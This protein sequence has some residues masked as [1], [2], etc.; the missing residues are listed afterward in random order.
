MKS[1]FFFQGYMYFQKCWSVLQLID[2]DHF[3]HDQNMFATT[4]K[5]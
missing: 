5:G 2:D 3:Q 1:V 4:V